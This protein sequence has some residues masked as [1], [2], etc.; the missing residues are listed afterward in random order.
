[1]NENINNLKNIISDI[2]V[3]L[4]S[5]QISEQEYLSINNKLKSYTMMINRVLAKCKSDNLEIPYNY[6]RDIVSHLKGIT[7]THYK[8][9]KPSNGSIG[10]EDVTDAYKQELALM[11]FNI[12]K[13]FTNFN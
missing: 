12:D 11:I 2:M 13:Y 1:M 6:T 10:I 8:D 7:I 5:N 9:Y 3:I 4:P